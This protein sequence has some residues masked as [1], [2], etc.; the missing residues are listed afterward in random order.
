MAKVTKIEI[1]ESEPVAGKVRVSL[2]I[3]GGK[4]VGWEIDQG[5][6]TARHHIAVTIGNLIVGALGG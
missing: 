5:S 4:R 6:L 3:V 1:V 2:L